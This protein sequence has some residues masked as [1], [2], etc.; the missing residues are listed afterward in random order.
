MNQWTIDVNEQDFEFSV[1]EQSKRVPVLV[2]FWAPWCGPCRM[3][4]P[5]YEAAAGRFADPK[6]VIL[7]HFG[8]RRTQTPLDRSTDCLPQALVRANPVLFELDAPSA[9]Q[10]R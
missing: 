7:V 1:L 2:D 8:D 6:T 3:M 10:P 4:A 9:Q 5:G